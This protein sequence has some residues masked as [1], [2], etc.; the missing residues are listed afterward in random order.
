MKKT[1]IFDDKSPRWN[2]N[3]RINGITLEAY[4][5]RLD[6]RLQ[7]YRCLL[8]RDVYEC[9]GI[10]ITRESLVAGWVISSVPHFE[11]KYHFKPNGAIEIIL[12]E[13]ES[14]IRYA[15]PSEEES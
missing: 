11:F 10:P 6:D 4:E 14:D 9:L 13:M 7:M 8:L 5:C 1:I 3:E 2:K 15:F 12:P